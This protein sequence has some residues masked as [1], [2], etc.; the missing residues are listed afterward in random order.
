MGALRETETEDQEQ[1]TE[2]PSTSQGMKMCFG[3][4]VTLLLLLLLLLLLFF[5]FFFHNK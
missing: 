4:L 1:P 3:Y 2:I 5:F